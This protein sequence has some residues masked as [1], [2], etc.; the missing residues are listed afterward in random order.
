MYDIDHLQLV[1]EQE[2][3][4]E[5]IYH[6]PLDNFHTFEGDHNMVGL[7]FAQANE[8]YL[9]RQAI[10]IRTDQMMNSKRAQQQPPVVQQSPYMGMQ[11]QQVQDFFCTQKTQILGHIHSWNITQYGKIFRLGSIY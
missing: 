8:A 7:S 6:A 9:F 11:Q 10:Q 4:R 5:F 1:W 2:I 3:Y